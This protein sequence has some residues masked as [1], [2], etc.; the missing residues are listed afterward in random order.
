[1]CTE[2][3]SAFHVQTLR[4]DERAAQCEVVEFFCCQSAVD[5]HFFFVP[6]VKYDSVCD[7]TQQI[8][9]TYLIAKKKHLKIH[10]NICIMSSHLSFLI[11]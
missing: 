4:I 5:I 3:M 9:C 8:G 6:E 7:I 1:M 10:F 11:Y 2:N